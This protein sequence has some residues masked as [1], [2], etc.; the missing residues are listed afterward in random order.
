MAVMALYSIGI[1]LMQYKD[2][3]D[4][5]PVAVDTILF[6]PFIDLGFMIALFSSFFIGA[7][8]SDGAFRNKLI[9]GH[10]RASMYLANFLTCAATGVF[11]LIAYYIFALSLGI[12]LLGMPLTGPQAA[13]G[14]IFAGLMASWAFASF[15]TF[16]S[17][18]IQSKASSAIVAIAFA[19]IFI[20]GFMYSRMQESETVGTYIMATEEDGS[21]STQQ[22][23]APN[24]RYLKERQRAAY[25]MCLD[26]FPSGQALQISMGDSLDLTLMVLCSSFIILA[27]NAF[28][29]C[30]FKRR[31]LK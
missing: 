12:P 25:Q 14:M 13:F 3:M 31:D 26:F 19:A 2:K 9:V 18:L 24:P 30:I 29:I 6:S 21:V 7:E 8:F 27:L 17:M 20:F 5:L 4:G 16:L 1:S 22:V 10:G 23:E 15:Y 28:G 11:L